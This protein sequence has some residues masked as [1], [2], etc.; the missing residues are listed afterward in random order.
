MYGTTQYVF[1]WIGV[2]DLK[3]LLTQEVFIH[4]FTSMATRTKMANCTQPKR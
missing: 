2:C 3:E 4:S 1:L